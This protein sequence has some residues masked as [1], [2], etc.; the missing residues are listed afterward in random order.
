MKWIPWLLLATVIPAWGQFQINYLNGNIEQPVGRAFDL[1]SVEPGA[2]VAI[3]FRL[4]NFFPIAESLEFLSV[5]GAG[6]SISNPSLPQF[7]LTLGPSQW[8][9][10]T[11]TF[12]TS[13]QGSYTATLD[14]VGIT[15]LLSAIVPV[16]LTRQ[17]VTVSGTRPL[18]GGTVDFGVIERG[19]S[20][21][22]RVLLVNQTSATLTVPAL[23]ISGA[24]FAM[25][26]NLPAG[27][28]L[29]PT[30][31]VGFDIQFS[32]T[33]DSA[34]AGVLSI[35]ARSYPMMGIG[36]EPPLP[37]PRISMSLPQNGSAQQGTLTLMFDSISRANGSGTVTLNFTPA[38]GLPVSAN[39]A[40]M[41]FASGGQTANFTV[42]PGDAEGRF[43]ALLTA[44]FQTGTT[45]GTLTITAQL[46]EFTD[47][48]T[49]AIAPATVGL[50]AAQAV[51]S[52][53]LIEIDL[54][55]FDN[56]RSAGALSFTFFDGLGNMVGGAIQADGANTF[57][58]FFKNATSG[59][60]A[61]RAV[62]PVAGD[63]SQIQ[64][65]RAEITNSVGSAGTGR[66]N[67]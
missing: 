30:T 1:G 57:A 42:S 60:F 63:A 66:T 44:P 25:S 6:F 64:S 17:L 46:G 19:A 55:G 18:S 36:I 26:A 5:N 9:D 54:S 14:S 16:E 37:R 11:V 29:T 45:A 24:G 41:A 51:R 15:I 48:Q 27:I 49:I 3:P 43:G 38:A 2:T 33:T 62:F 47:Q 22:R 21:T 52:T 8:L 59:T 61:L 65:F 35:G 20:A 12:Q 28:L 4:R 32:P 40:G 34:A 56:T 39:D 13:G 23:Q 7:P 58:S 67:F 10:F 31:N 53:G 50:T